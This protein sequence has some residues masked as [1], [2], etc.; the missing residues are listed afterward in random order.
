MVEGFTLFV[1]LAVPLVS[2]CV[3]SSGLHVTLFL[4]TL[5]LNVSTFATVPAFYTFWGG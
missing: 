4:V 5:F 2:W 1:V 3:T